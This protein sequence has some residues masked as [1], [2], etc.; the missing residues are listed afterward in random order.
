GVGWHVWGGCLAR[1]TRSRQRDDVAGRLSRSA[2]L[3]A[4][5]HAFCPGRPP[6]LS[7][8]TTQAGELRI[9]GGSDDSFASVLTLHKSGATGESGCGPL[10]FARFTR[11]IVKE[12]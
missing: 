10:A 3:S 4:Q 8:M 2:P 6:P 7:S 12:D 1:L 9:P 5:R 11:G